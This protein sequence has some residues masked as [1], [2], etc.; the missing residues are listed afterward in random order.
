MTGACQLGGASGDTLGI[1]VIL[2]ILKLSHL[3][4]FSNSW[5]RRPWQE[6]SWR[7]HTLSQLNLI[8]LTPD[9]TF[10]HS[11]S[12]SKSWGLSCS[13]GRP[14]TTP[15]TLKTPETPKSSK[16]SHMQMSSCRLFHFGEAVSKTAPLFFSLIS[17]PLIRQRSRC[18]SSFGLDR[19]S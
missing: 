18:G 11:L 15:K 2:M 1:L 9:L 6:N 3:V 14:D 16:T 4:H 13:D 7:S 8:H 10:L 17:P 19:L 12:C 5:Q